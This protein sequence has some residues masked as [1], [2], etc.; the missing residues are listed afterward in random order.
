MNSKFGMF[1]VLVLSVMML[2]I[3]ATSIANAQEYNE[4]YEE[5]ERS[6]NGYSYGYN[7]EKYNYD[8]IFGEIDQDLLNEILEEKDID[9]LL[10]LSKNMDLELILELFNQ[11]DR[12][13][14][15]ELVDGKDRILLFELFDAIDND[16]LSDTGNLGA[17]LSIELALL[18]VLISTIVLSACIG[19]GICAS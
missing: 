5:N 2:L 18:I 14:L 3:P 1:S 16:L 19:F 13:L 10:E 12:E 7:D 8:K 11:L 9:L 17:I 6:S 15:V 4:H